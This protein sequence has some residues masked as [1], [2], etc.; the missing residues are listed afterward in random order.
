MNKFITSKFVLLALIWTAGASAQTG[1]QEGPNTNILRWASGTYAYTT[2]SE[3]RD[4]GW[5]RFHMNVYSDG[6]RTMNM[7]HDLSARSAQFTVV[8]R[9]A[10]DFRPIETY[11]S[12]WVANGFKGSTIIR[13]NGDSLTASANGPAGQHDQSMDVPAVF[14][15]GTH[16]VSADGWHLWSDS[17]EVGVDQTSKI[18]SLE[19]STDVTKPPLGT[20]RDLAFNRLGKE[21]ITVP[22]G[23]FETIHYDLSGSQ[24]WI[25]EQDRLMVRMVIERFDRDYVLTSFKSE[26][27]E[28]SK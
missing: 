2:L 24:V 8:H 19:A 27:N 3:P 10:A 12:Y 20:L 1:D 14:S 26:S 21:T 15:V 22:A 16:P 18:Y 4:R 28:E 23:T 9:V 11:L 6:S 5:E 13:V 7:W 17:G 25:T